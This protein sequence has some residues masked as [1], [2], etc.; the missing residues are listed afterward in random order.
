MHKPRTTIK[1]YGRFILQA[2]DPT[3]PFCSFIHGFHSLILS[4]CAEDFV[5]AHILKPLAT[6]RCLIS[7][8]TK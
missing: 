1:S 6:P 3:T 4:L 2:G 5:F 7:L 8:N